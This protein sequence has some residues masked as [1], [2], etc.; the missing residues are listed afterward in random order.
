MQHTLVNLTVVVVLTR[1][2]QTLTPVH[3]FSF[4]MDP[5]TALP[6]CTCTSWLPCS[7]SVLPEEET[8]EG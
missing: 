3:M 6:W 7:P 4:R 1:A 5:L 2:L 8:A